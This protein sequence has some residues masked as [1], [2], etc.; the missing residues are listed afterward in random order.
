MGVAKIER[1][2]KARKDQGKCNQCGEEIKRGDAYIWWTVGFRSNYKHCRCTKCP[3]PSRAERESNPKL[4]MIWAAE[5]D[6]NN[7]V[8]EANERDDIASALS[9]AA[10]GVRDAQQEWQD[11]YDEMEQH[12]QGGC[13]AMEEIQEKI[14]QCEELANALEEASNSMDE[15]PG[16]GEESDDFIER[17]R[18]DAFEAWSSTSQF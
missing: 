15:E 2:K 4:S 12:F 17:L 6:F 16:E 1:V 13:P 11:T 8:S 14:D 5:D 3:E 9:S 18:E 10:Q 7:A